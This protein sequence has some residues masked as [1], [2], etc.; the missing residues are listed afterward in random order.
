[1]NPAEEELRYQ[2]WFNRNAIKTLLNGS[3]EDRYVA[4]YE[5]P[6]PNQED[7]SNDDFW[8]NYTKE[9]IVRAIRMV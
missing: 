1:M 8:D 2:V 3:Y 9:E 4:T 5:A 6:I 7:L